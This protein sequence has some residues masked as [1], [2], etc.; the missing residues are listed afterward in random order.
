MIA[1]DGNEF[2]LGDVD[3]RVL[4]ALPEG[5]SLADAGVAA[6]ERFTVRLDPWQ[7]QPPRS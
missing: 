7:L 3:D 2:V 6:R 4:A 1:D 5:S